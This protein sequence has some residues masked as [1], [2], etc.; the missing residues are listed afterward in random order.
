MRVA[1]GCPV[2]I[3]LYA[4]E[5]PFCVETLI[6][7]LSGLHYRTDTAAKAGAFAAAVSMMP[8]A[9]RFSLEDLAPQLRVDHGVSTRQIRHLLDGG[10]FNPEPLRLELIRDVARDADA[11]V[12]ERSE[13]W[14]PEGRP[15]DI[16][17]VCLAGPHFAVPV[18]WKRIWGP[19]DHQGDGPPTWESVDREGAVEV[20]RAFREDLEKVAI[21]HVPPLVSFDCT[22]GQCDV[23]RQDVDRLGFESILEVGP[24]Y[25]GHDPGDPDESQ[26][27]RRLHEQIPFM[28]GEDPP[29][30][31]RHGEGAEFLVPYQGEDPSYAIASPRPMV[32]PGELGGHR[33]RERAVELGG[34]AA[35]VVRP[36]AAKRLRVGC[37]QHL[38][39][40]GLGVATT[41]LSAYSAILEGRLPPTTPC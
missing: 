32:K 7:V 20:L 34:L 40:F 3:E 35:S 27:P 23:L 1:V 16:T 17:T 12:L 10:G 37:F 28:A 31:R 29:A 39:D 24:H 33:G 9:E 11:V 5:R 36:E 2:P 26:I 19:A 25:T 6:S 8:E 14:T 18:G 4:P 13:S 30:P 41:I 22:H 21:S 15:Y 38:N